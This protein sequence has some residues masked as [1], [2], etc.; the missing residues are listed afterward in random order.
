M[1]DISKSDWKKYQE[2]IGDWQERYMER[3]VKEYIVYLSSDCPASE[4]FWEL[5][6]RI[7]RDKKNPG[8]L[9]ELRKSD[10]IYDLL[11][12]IRYKVITMDDLK[13]FSVE[14]QEDIKEFMDRT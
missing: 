11:H 7:K 3:L 4:K 2:K 9:I 10:A 8:V 5:E 12:L 14:L 6:K 1:H 13:D